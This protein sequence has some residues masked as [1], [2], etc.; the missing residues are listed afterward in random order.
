MK[1]SWSAKSLSMEEFKIL[2]ELNKYYIDLISDRVIADLHKLR[3]KAFLLSGDDSGLRSVWEEICAH[4]QGEE[5]MYWDAYENT[6]ENHVSSELRQQPI[7]IINLMLYVAE[8][9]RDYNK[10]VD[11]EVIKAVLEQVLFKAEEFTNQNIERYIN[12][13][14]ED[15]D[16]EEEG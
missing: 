8:P 2:S 7:P 9:H 12:N 4:V 16:L 11:E 15:E 3:D 6:I 10:G 14:F 1:E 5:S 13:D